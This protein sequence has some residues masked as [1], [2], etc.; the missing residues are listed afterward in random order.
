M[1]TPFTTDA[2][3]DV[4]E[5]ALRELTNFLINSGV[6]GLIPT[7]GAGEYVYLSFE[8]WKKV[9]EIIVDEVNGRVPVVTGILDPGTKNVVHRA[10]L[11]KDLGADAIMVLVHQY[12]F[13]RDD[14]IFRHFETI[15]IKSEMPI[16]LYNST[17]LSGSDINPKVIKRLVDGNH[18]NSI[19]DSTHDLMHVSKLIQICEEKVTVLKGFAEDFLPTLRIGAQGTVTTGCNCF[20]KILVSIWNNFH[21]GKYEKAEELHFSLLSLLDLMK[22]GIDV[23]IAKESLNIM[24]VQVGPP[25]KPLTPVNNEEKKELEK[26]LI[27]LNL[28]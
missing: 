10:K 13:P 3:Q 15:A 16:M 22:R 25:R 5:E 20:P 9:N 21:Q 28:I 26:I 4:D 8:E 17:R 12:Y 2:S 23:R 7:G 14:E 18:I 24:G 19:K 11:A 1:L 27:K 6:H